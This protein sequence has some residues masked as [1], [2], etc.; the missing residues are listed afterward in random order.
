MIIGVLL[1]ML[2]QLVDASGQDS[3]LDLG[4]ASVG[5]VSAVSL[6][7]GSLFVLTDH[8]NFHLSNNLPDGLRNGRVFP[9]TVAGAG[10]PK[11]R[12]WAR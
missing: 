8:G 10:I 2:G 6:D 9:P 5:S 4:G 11:R 7:N 3:D 1:Q 12:R